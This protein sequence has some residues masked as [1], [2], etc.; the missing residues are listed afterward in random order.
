MVKKYKKRRNIFAQV[1]YSTETDS[2]L[3]INTG[4]VF[5]F[6]GASNVTLLISISEMLAGFVTN[7]FLSIGVSNFEFTNIG[8]FLSNSTSNLLYINTNSFSFINIYSFLFFDANGFLFINTNNLLSDNI[9]LF[10]NFLPLFLISTLFY[11][12]YSVFTYFLLLYF[13]AISLSFFLI[14][15]YGQK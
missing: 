8:S 15:Y 7:S 6:F 13:I 12:F 9:S 5:L 2:F 14:M 10:I 11:F 1:I 4:S 3:F